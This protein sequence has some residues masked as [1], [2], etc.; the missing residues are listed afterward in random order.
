MLSYWNRNE[1]VLVG[2]GRPL[3]KVE[4]GSNSRSVYPEPVQI[5]RSPGPT[6]NRFVFVPHVANL[7]IVKPAAGS[8]VRIDL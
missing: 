1:R 6:R 8:F 5:I 4:A 3:R 7:F 2:L